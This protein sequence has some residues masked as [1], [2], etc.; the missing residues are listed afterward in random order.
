MKNYVCFG[1]ILWDGLPTGKTLGGAPL[2]LGLRLQSFGNEVKIISRIG[3]DDL[4]DEIINELKYRNFDYSHVQIDAHEASGYVDVFLDEK[5]SASYNIRKPV[6]WDFIELNKINLD[7]VRKADAFIYG[8]LASRNENSKRTLLELISVAKYKIFDI[9]LRSPHY[10]FSTIQ[11]MMEE[12]DII[13]M[14]DEELFIISDF[15]NTPYNS[16]E[17]NI[18][19]IAEKVKCSKICITK[20]KHGAVFYENGVFYYNSG[21][22]INVKD[23]IGAGDSFLATFIH[24]YLTGTEIT[25]SLEYACAMGAIVSS[26]EGANPVINEQYLFNFVNGT[27]VVQINNLN[28]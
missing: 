17:K 21:F 7:L 8:S 2:N 23:T 3:K 22:R 6:A 14:N 26:N 16:L 28:K 20:G 15:F 4:G 5:G 18:V 1:E 12:S 24:Y 10:D 13:K 19:F 9:N 25:K 27:E 11:Q